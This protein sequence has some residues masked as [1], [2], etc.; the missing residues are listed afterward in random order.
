M[1]LVQPIDQMAFMVGLAEINVKAQCLRLIVQ[2]SGNIVQR[3]GPVNLW[4][5]CPQQV[6]VGS[7][8]DENDRAISQTIL[9]VKLAL[10]VS[11]TLYSGY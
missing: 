7:V 11:A 1:R 6:E 10:D 8:K 4:L 5:S 2:P 9:T 3:V